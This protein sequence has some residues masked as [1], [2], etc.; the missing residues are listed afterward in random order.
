[1]PDHASDD[2]GG[3]RDLGGVHRDR[4]AQHVRDGVAAHRPGSA[5]RQPRARD[6]DGLDDVSG[7]PDRPRDGDRGDD[8]RSRPRGF[9]GDAARRAAGRNRGMMRARA[10]LPWVS[11]ADAGPTRFRPG[12]VAAWLVLMAYL[13][14]VALP[15]VWVAMSSLKTQAAIAHQPLAPPDPDRLQWDNFPRA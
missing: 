9:R 2:P 12:R 4:R 8:V 15:M 3:H 6:L 7:L 13:A 1:L 10:R 11:R 14:W 5:G